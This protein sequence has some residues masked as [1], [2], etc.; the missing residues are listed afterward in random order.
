MML[1]D[2]VTPRL[3]DLEQ[4]MVAN[5]PPGGNWRHIPDGLSDRVDQ[6]KRRS[7]KGIV[8][9]TYYGRLRGNWPS[10]TI[11]TYFSRVGNGCFLHPHERRLIS[12]REGARLQAFPDRYRFEGPRRAQY[13]QVGNA[14]PPLLGYAVGRT[15]GENLV[16]ADLFSGAGGLSL[17]MELAGHNVVLA[18]DKQKS[19]CETLNGAHDADIAEH[20]DLSDETTQRALVAEIKRRAGGRVDVLAGGPPCQ[21]FSTAGSR[22]FHDDRAN[23]FWIPFRMAEMLK[24]R[25]LVVENV[26]GVL[27]AAKRTI[28]QR[29]AEAMLSLGLTPQMRVLRADEY[30]V[31]Q[32]RTRVF[33]V[34]IRDGEWHLPQPECSR[35]EKPVSLFL[36]PPVTVDEAIS[37]LPSLEP[38]QHMHDVSLET[39][40]A[41]EFQRW[42][43]GEICVEE[44]IELRKRRLDSTANGDWGRT[45]GDSAGRLASAL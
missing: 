39:P 18:A 22:D 7:E 13:E 10:Y 28:P 31:P 16:V 19:A 6:I 5:I 30:F 14:V 8:H 40:A 26:Q 17:G 36:E 32:R 27:S 43:R 9:T 38:G 29:V 3:S 11:N 1:Y 20:A 25:I 21:S 42:A 44:F 12:L 45:P 24:P 4:E 23:L 33:F 15:L 34:G 37:D 41:S 35:P 2:H